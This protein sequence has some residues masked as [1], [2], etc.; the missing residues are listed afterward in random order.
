MSLNLKSK[1]NPKNA[2][3][4]PNHKLKQIPIRIQILA[5]KPNSY[6]GLHS[7]TNPTLYA[8]NHKS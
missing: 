7:R 6:A 8:L 2:E 3:P 4:K 1:P 5:L